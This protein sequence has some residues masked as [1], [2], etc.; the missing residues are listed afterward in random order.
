MNRQLFALIGAVLLLAACGSSPKVSYYTLRTTPTADRQGASAGY[1]V[2]IGPI[3]VPD[4]IDRPQVV[5]RTGSNQVAINEMARWAEP[6][7]AEIP[8][9][10]ADN[11]RPLLPGAHVSIYPQG[12]DSEG[13]LSV[14]IDV[15][16]F[17]SAPGEAATV[18]ILWTLRSAG[19][20]PMKG[21][22]IVREPVAGAGYDALVAAHARALTAVSRDIA[23]AIPAARAAAVA[24]PASAAKP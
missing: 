23:A 19:K 5:I 22:S 9:V 4:M 2:V 8:R 20:A 14:A 12:A 18:D 1:P 21:R 10:I 17:D 24:L 16:S 11:L 13:A 6:P 15:Q 3:S 7:R